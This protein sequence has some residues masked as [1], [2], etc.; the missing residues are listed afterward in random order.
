MPLP[1]FCIKPFLIYKKINKNY[2]NFLLI[3]V[4]GCIII[5]SIMVYLVGIDTFMYTIQ[6]TI[7][8]NVYIFILGIGN[9]LYPNKRN[10]LPVCT[11]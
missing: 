11:H 3:F 10:Y 4:F 6:Y 2:H 1:S 8:T 9:D 5:N 7:H